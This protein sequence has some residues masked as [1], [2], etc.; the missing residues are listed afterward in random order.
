MP[1]VFNVISQIRLSLLLAVSDF[2]RFMAFCGSTAR[3]LLFRPGKWLRWRLL[4][5]QFYNVGVASIPVVAITGA[6][7]F[8]FIFFKDPCRRTS[9]LGT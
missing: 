9:T 7:T 6:F 2:G 8:S 1:M 5:T 3:W 4:R